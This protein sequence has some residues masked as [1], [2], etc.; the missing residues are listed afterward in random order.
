MLLRQA[1]LDVGIDRDPVAE[2]DQ[3]VAIIAHVYGRNGAAPQDSHTPR[4][5]HM[6]ENC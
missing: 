3:A 5:I 1:V 6:R 4:R 2:I